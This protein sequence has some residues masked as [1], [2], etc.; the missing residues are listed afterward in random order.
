MH[1]KEIEDSETLAKTAKIIEQ[2]IVDMDAG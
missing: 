1:G 2:A